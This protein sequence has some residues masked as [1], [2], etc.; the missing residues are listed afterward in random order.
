MSPELPVADTPLHTGRR[1]KIRRRVRRASHRPSR[2]HRVSPDTVL[3]EAGADDTVVNPAAAMLPAELLQPG[4]IIVLILKPS[5]WFIL[6]EALPT[7]VTL[8]LLFAVSVAARNML[9]Y[10]PGARELT[11]VAVAL[12]LMRLFWQFLEWLGRVYVLT[13]RRMIRVRGV[14]R[15]H[16][17]EA[18]L[19][20]IQNTSMYISAR[21]R[22]FG[23]GT[24]GFAT[25]G[26]G[27]IEV[28]WRMIA[29]PR[30]VHQIVVQTL[31][32]YR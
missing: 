29:K 9:N 22:L 24:L 6:L 32:R 17:F 16:I 14:V 19:K 25:A 7:L 21:E 5:S 8:T 26:T 20:N 31:E 18:S 11:V 10:G 12:M 13:D 1:A 3:A 23:L 2:K 15:V 28:F 27:P 30:E 4:E